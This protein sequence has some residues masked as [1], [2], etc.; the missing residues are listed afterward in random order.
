MTIRC[1]YTKF[2]HG[3]YWELDKYRIPQFPFAPTDELV[4]NELI[5]LQDQKGC[6]Y[7]YVVRLASSTVSLIPEACPFFIHEEYSWKYPYGYHP[8]HIAIVTYTRKD[9]TIVGI[10]KYCVQTMEGAGGAKI[11]LTPAGFYMKKGKRKGFVPI[12]E[13]KKLEHQLRTEI[14]RLTRKNET[15]E[16]VLQTILGLAYEEGP[17]EEIYKRSYSPDCT[18]RE[19]HI[20]R[21]E[22]FEVVSKGGPFERIRHL[23]DHFEHINFYEP[24]LWYLPYF[25]KKNR[26]DIEKGPFTFM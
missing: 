10:D 19:W 6:F 15:E 25:I 8:A 12:E 11:V 17:E 14:L 7:L 23:L 2:I 1:F 21:N 13:S 4:D 3:K 18:S 5:C 16:Y 20:L 22:I 9:G 26:L 24:P